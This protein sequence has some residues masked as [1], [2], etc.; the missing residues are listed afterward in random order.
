MSKPSMPDICKPPTVRLP[1]DTHFPSED[2]HRARRQQRRDVVLEQV[3][4]QAGELR[5]LLFRL[6]GY[7]EVTHYH[8]AGYM[9]AEC[10]DF[11]VQVNAK[12]LRVTTNMML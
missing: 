9:R 10:G 1:V 8:K 5:Y 2:K 6:A 4:H 11:W 7:G 12:T 3:E